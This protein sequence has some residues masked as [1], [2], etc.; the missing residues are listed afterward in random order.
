VV[1]SDRVRPGEQGCATGREGSR[2]LPVDP[3]EQEYAL[4]ERLRQLRK[5]TAE[6]HGVPV[7]ALGSVAGSG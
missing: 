1:V 3:E 6:K 5:E 2:G 4:F 7:Y